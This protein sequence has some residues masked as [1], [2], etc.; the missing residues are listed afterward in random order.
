MFLKSL[1]KVSAWY[2][3]V[4]SRPTV[5]WGGGGELCSGGDSESVDVKRVCTTEYGTYRSR[6]EIGVLSA[7]AYAATLS[8]IVE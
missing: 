4:I 2:C 8:V 1:P 3:G 7:E 6:V 5:G